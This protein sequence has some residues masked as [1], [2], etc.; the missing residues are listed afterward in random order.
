MKNALKKS[1]GGKRYS[2]DPDDRRWNLIEV[3][4]PGAKPGG[5]PLTVDLRPV[6]HGILYVIRAGGAW[7]LLPRDSFPPWGTVYGDFRRWTRDGTWKRLH[8][9]LRAEVRRRA[10]RHKH[11]TA[12]WLDSPSVKTT[13]L[14]EFE[15]DLISERT[16]AGLA[17]ARARGRKGGAPFKTTPPPT[18]S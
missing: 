14:S 11:P 12:A 10:G 6:L 18:C 16:R 3:L 8:D 9:T 13:A 4:L 2:T 7:R 17:S 1:A 15:R 5:R